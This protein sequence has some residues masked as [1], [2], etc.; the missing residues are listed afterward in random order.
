MID[1]L[2]RLKKVPNDSKLHQIIR[3]LDQDKDG[4]I[5]INDALKVRRLLLSAYNH[6]HHVSDCITSSHSLYLKINA[7]FFCFFLKLFLFIYFMLN[8]C[9]VLS[10]I[11]S[12][13]HSNAVFHLFS[14]FSNSVFHNQWML[15]FK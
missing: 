2:K 15:I 12:F 11:S 6:H 10:V 13:Q 9:V 1:A 5:D 7:L 8:R 14:M 3:V 4:V